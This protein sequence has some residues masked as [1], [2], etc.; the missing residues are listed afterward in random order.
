[1]RNKR[2]RGQAVVELAVFASIIL[3]GFG[4]LLSHLQRSND[5][6]YVQMEAFRRALEKANQY[7]PASGG[8]GASVQMNL[9]H[10]RRYAETGG[11]YG[12]GSPQTL[13]GSAQ[14]L[15]AVPSGGE[16]ADSLVVYRI[17]DDEK[18]ANY[19]DYVPAE[20]RETKYF[21]IE[22][23]TTD[24][25]TEY[26]GTVEKQEDAAGITNIRTA[27][28]KD[29]LHTNITYTVR[30]TDSGGDNPENDKI[31]EKGEFW[32]IQQGGYRDPVDGQYKYSSNA[33]G[34]VTH[35][36]RAWRTDFGGY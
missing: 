6:Q 5:Q 3:L 11:D 16:Q 31:E 14:V 1:M 29:S 30:A 18:V 9:V 15:W 10:N 23:T 12:K 13:S 32:N 25:G 17:N 8:A 4:L 21:T 19:R 35:E 36:E 24:S 33:L 20:E 22:D 26:T 27:E 7:T 28:L 34:T 2:Q